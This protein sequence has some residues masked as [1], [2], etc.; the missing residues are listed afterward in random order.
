M[1]ATYLLF[2]I[3]IT[4]ETIRT[5]TRGVCRWF[6]CTSGCSVRCALVRL[7][8]PVTL[9]P[10]IKGLIYHDEASIDGL[11]GPT[12]NG[13]LK[14]KTAMNVLGCL[15]NFKKGSELAF[16]RQKLAMPENR[17]W[18][19]IPRR[20]GAIHATTRDSTPGHHIIHTPAE[21]HSRDNKQEA[22]G[23]VL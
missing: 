5:D 11:T 10:N 12:C 1:K 21:L 18:W 20:Y 15:N 13:G 4:R 9:K 14:T 3:E 6:G 17:R 16:K 19:R 23:D 8:S 2:S 22:G 7:S